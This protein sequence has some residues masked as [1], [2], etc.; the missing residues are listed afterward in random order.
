M[1]RVFNCP[2]NENSWNVTTSFNG[3]YLYFLF[4]ILLVMVWQIFVKI[5][6]YLCFHYGISSVMVVFCF[7]SFF[8]HGVANVFEC[9]TI[10]VFY[11][12]SSLVMGWHTFVKTGTES[13]ATRYSC[14]RSLSYSC[15]TIGK[16]FPKASPCA[17]CIIPVRFLQISFIKHTSRIN[18]TSYLSLFMLSVIFY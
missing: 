4:G 2:L 15:G 9:M 3:G 5:W 14:V 6:R 16:I 1:L 10:I 7:W 12:W 11:F 17:V 13:G 8:S 18:E